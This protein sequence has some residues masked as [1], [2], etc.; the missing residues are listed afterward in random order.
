VTDKPTRLVSLDALRGFDMIWIVGGREVV[1]AAA[2]WT[3]WSAL[4][5]VERE[6][7]HVEW[8]GFTFWDLVF[9]LFLF[10]AGVS[11]PLS[12]DARRAKGHTDGRVRR[13][14]IVR[15]LLLVALG[16]LY[17]VGPS[18][19]FSNVRY[20]SVL[21]RIGLA[22]M[23]AALIALR[24][25]VRGQC[26]WVVALLFGYWGALTLVPVP[27]QA[28]PSL[29]PGETLTDWV[30][31]ALLPGRLHRTVRDPEGL[32]ATLPAI[33]TAL[34]GMLAG[35]VLSAPIPGWRRVLWLTLGGLLALALGAWWD[36][37]FPIN[38]NLWSSSFVLWTAGW[39]A[40][41]LAAFHLVVDLWGAGR[42]A[43]VFTVVGTNS[44]AAYLLSRFVDF[45]ELSARVVRGELLPA[46]V[47]L[48]AL[49]GVLYFLY[50]RRWFLRV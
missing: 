27:G 23:F 35:R 31:R 17:N 49:W 8:N 9:P 16:V 11:F 22:W 2:A 19:D 41:L 25:G 44:I 14:V 13:H 32:L 29:A 30:D 3:G 36:T 40:L 28:A 38:K 12:L 39:S 46:V 24:A 42:L 37:F 20:A 7:H 6:L 34:L 4:E 1:A 48:A 47:G 33:A 18:F 50:R 10:L 26:L 5:R 21:G 15:G 43:F 45:E